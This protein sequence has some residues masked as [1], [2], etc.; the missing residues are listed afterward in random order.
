M[1]P[2]PALGLAA[3]AGLM[4]PGATA[5]LRGV[6]EGGR[7]SVVLAYQRYGRGKTLAF[8]V[9]DSWNWQMDA[10]VSLEDM[11]FESFWRQLL[12]WLVNDVPARV[13]VAA[14]MECRRESCPR[15]RPA[16]GPSGARRGGPAS[17]QAA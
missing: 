9:Y 16:A 17:P 5:L 7:E 2:G 8:P 6:D 10:S 11:A 14:V 13:M 3:P 1:K 12:R 15:S 4:T